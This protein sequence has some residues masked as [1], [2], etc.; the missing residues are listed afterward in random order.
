MKSFKLDYSAM[1][2]ITLLEINQNLVWQ[3]E[4]AEK[5]AQNKELAQKAALQLRLELAGKGLY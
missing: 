1:I 5:L 2:D 3:D 4:Q